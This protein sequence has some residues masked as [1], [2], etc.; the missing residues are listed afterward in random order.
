MPVWIIT[1]FAQVLGKKTVLQVE[2]DYP[3][4]VARVNKNT[5]SHSRTRAVYEMR[6]GQSVGCSGADSAEQ[7]I[8]SVA[9]K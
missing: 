7:R 2:V 3:T 4:R 9:I 6:S 1:F 5:A 8:H